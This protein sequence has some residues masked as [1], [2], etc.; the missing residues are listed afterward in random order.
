M[1]VLVKI[2]FTNI[3]NKDMYKKIKFTKN[4][5]ILCFIISIIGLIFI[6]ITIYKY[7]QKIISEELFMVVENLD[8]PTK[9]DNST[10]N[11]NPTKI[12][13]AQNIT[14]Q[15]TESDNKQPGFLDL[16]QLSIPS[17][18]DYVVRTVTNALSSVRPDVQGPPGPMGQ[19]GPQGQNG[20]TFIF[21]GPLR[22]IKQPTLVVDRKTNTL[23]MSNQ[24]YTPQQTWTMSSDNKILNSSN[25]NDCLNM[26]D[27]G[28]LE[29]A[30]CINSK[31]WN[32]IGLTG[33]LQAMK[34]MGG[35]NKCL[36]LKNTPENG[37]DNQ[38]NIL[39]DDCSIGGPE[40]AWNFL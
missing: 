9:N 26:N 24:S 25:Q 18:K 8:N 11:D 17:I 6:G 15:P 28:N 16:K 31:T 12:D 3:V 14:T 34:P 32:Y 7:K 19:P 22:S 27:N 40:Q 37:V 20:G 5:N 13:S 36:T 29:I 39:L 30:N 23:F 33:Q 38:Y 10:K 1:L 35:K 21:R 2:L 4:I